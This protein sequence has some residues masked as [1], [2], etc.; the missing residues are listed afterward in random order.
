MSIVHNTNKNVRRP[1]DAM[2][3]LAARRGAHPATDAR[4][5]TQSIER[6]F[7]ILKEVSAASAN[8]MSLSAL[9]S[10]M[11]LNRTTI[12]RIVK[13]LTSVDAVRYDAGAKRYF[14]G[15]L[16]LEFG[17]AA[18]HQQLDL[19]TLCSPVLARI[20]QATGDTVFLMLRSGDDSI[21]I[22]R[23]LG[24]YPVKTLVAEIGTQRPLGIGAGGLAILSALPEHERTRIISSNAVRVLQFGS[25]AGKLAS[26]VRRARIEG[27][28]SSAAHGV[29]GV[30]SVG[31][32]ILDPLGRPL[33]A[34]S[35]TAIADR[36]LKSRQR[37]VIAMLRAEI[38]HLQLL[39][40]ATENKIETNSNAK[41]N[42]G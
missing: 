25:S 17:I 35:V 24:S 27:Y 31:L 33:A 8:G 18:R 6:A 30:I 9:V 2:L 1:S 39:L 26:A 10:R 13:C 38:D 20:A 15:P 7:A 40:Q 37:E 34:L 42:N 3:R 14:L 36:M 23:W 12:F 41:R 11:N 32:P 21:C 5:G 16:A 19:S 28:V 29:K 4:S 22:D